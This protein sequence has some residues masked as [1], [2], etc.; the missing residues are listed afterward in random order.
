MRTIIKEYQVLEFNELNEGQ[1][2]KVLEGLHDINLDGNPLSDSINEFKNDLEIL[3]F[4]NVEI[5]YTGF[6]SQ[7]DGASFTGKYTIP[8]VKEGIDRLKKFK[9]NCG[10]DRFNELAEELFT[11][12]FMG[13][14]NG[15]TLE[16]ERTSRHYSH[17]YTVKCDNEALNEWSKKYM[18][19]I[20]RNLE[21]Q[22]EYL[23]SREA[24]IETIEAN[25]Y[26]F[27]SETLRIEK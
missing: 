1:K 10:I 8:S 5:E 18:T 13:I 12:D 7:G 27:N 15:E 17:A 25:E 21:I 23:Q 22:W 6:C 3:G 16:I 14:D 11:L 9:E 26:E 2:N 20:Y 4:S 19:A 24:I